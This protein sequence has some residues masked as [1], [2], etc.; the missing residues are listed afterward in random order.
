MFVDPEIWHIIDVCCKV[1]SLFRS[2]GIYYEINPETLVINPEG[3]LKAFWCHLKSH[4]NH[5]KFFQYFDSNYKICRFP[6]S[7]E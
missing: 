5:L 2:F 1:Y 3:K 7:P 6:Y 4:N